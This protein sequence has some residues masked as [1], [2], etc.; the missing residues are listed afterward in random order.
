MNRS[1]GV[2]CVSLSIGALVGFGSRAVPAAQAAFPAGAKIGFVDVL[3]VAR[4]SAEGQTAAAQLKAM[5]DKRVDEL[6]AKGKALQAQL[7]QLQKSGGDEAARA[8]LRAQIQQAQTA[9][10]QAQ[11][12]AGD[13]MADLEQRL[14][15]DFSR[16]LGPVIREV[17]TSRQLHLVLPTR[18][19][20][21]WADPALDLTGEVT[22][23]L[24][25]RGAGF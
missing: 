1:I 13:D 19:D 2:A 23:R 9:L 8:S 22:A 16:R 24:D 6:N 21:L 5:A 18:A 11:R 14:V 12:D 4:Q 3:R 15:V 7:D 17:A 20:F 10:V 25:K